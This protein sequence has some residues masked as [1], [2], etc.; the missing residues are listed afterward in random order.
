MSDSKPAHVWPLPEV[1]VSVINW[2]SGRASSGRLLGE[3]HKG[4]VVRVDDEIWTV[5]NAIVTTREAARF[6]GFSASNLRYFVKKGEIPRCELGP[7][8]H[9]YKLADIR[10]WQLLTG[11][12]HELD[13]R[14]GPV[15]RR[16][17]AYYEGQ[18]RD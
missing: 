16:I 17:K 2:K 6:L 18:R 14:L 9:R 8:S 7:H 13:V 15:S 4:W 1:T 3:S 12:A 5:D 11:R 10:A